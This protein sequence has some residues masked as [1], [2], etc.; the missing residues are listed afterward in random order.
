M[1]TPFIFV[2]F[3]VSYLFINKLILLED[4][5]YEHVPT[6]TVTDNNYIT[7]PPRPLR[8]PCGYKFDGVW[9]E[10]DPFSRKKSR[11]KFD[12][13]ETIS[14]N[15][16]TALRSGDAVDK[17]SMVNTDI[18]LSTADYAVEYRADGQLYVTLTFLWRDWRLGPYYAVFTK[19]ENGKK[20]EQNLDII[21]LEKSTIRISRLKQ[22]NLTAG[23]RIDIQY[24]KYMCATK[25]ELTRI[26]VR[27]KENKL[28]NLDPGRYRV[29]EKVR[30]NGCDSPRG[31][32]LWELTTA[33]AAGINGLTYLPKPGAA[34]DNKFWIT[35]LMTDHCESP[36][37]ATGS[38]R[39]IAYESAARGAS[40]ASNVIEI[41]LQT[42]KPEDVGVYYADFRTDDNNEEMIQIIQP[43][44]IPE[45]CLDE[46]LTTYMMSGHFFVKLP[47]RRYKVLPGYKF[48]VLTYNLPS[49]T[50]KSSSEAS[51][52]PL[53]S[54]RSGGG[55]V[56]LSSLK[57]SSG[58]VNHNYS[59]DGLSVTLNLEFRYRTFRQ[60]RGDVLIV[61]DGIY[62]A[63]PYVNFTSHGGVCGCG[64]WLRVRRH[65]WLQKLSEMGAPIREVNLLCSDSIDIFDIPIAER[66]TVQIP[67][68]KYL[69]LT[70]G[71]R[72]E[73]QLVEYH[74]EKCELLRI[75]VY[76]YD[77]NLYYL[78]TGRYRVTEKN[79]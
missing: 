69:N 74:C 3:P 10:R 6:L 29:I 9:R 35:Y 53:K 44:S 7:I 73:R 62:L 59:A 79:E 78:D 42:L 49:Y 4:S 25:C 70:A 40:V 19:D 32:Y 16:N 28:F 45:D 67:D 55:G 63:Y 20:M 71:Q 46:H 66:A 26:L 68:I 58:R 13:N 39:A 27:T 72:A 14:I 12:A 1:A 22:L 51:S 34:R 47:P 21:H 77:V 56:K 2:R 30:Q 43:P 38:M 75:V 5:I 23:Q 24:I 15:S 17:G 31:Y 64:V 33:D 37:D 57:L 60:G 50:N 8:I 36:F 48:F 11:K 54:K 65:L 41:D 52:E 61:K 18:R 76:T